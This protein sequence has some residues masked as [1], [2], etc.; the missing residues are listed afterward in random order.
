M[1]KAKNNSWFC[2][3]CGEESFTYLGRCA[4]CGAWGSLKESPKAEKVS[5]RSTF[6]TRA[7]VAAQKLSQIK[8]NKNQNRLSTGSEEFD[9]VLGGG[10]L[11]DSLI[12]LGGEPG[13]GK[14]TLLLQTA[15]A[16]AEQG[17]VLY[18]SAE[19]SSWQIKGRAERL[20]CSTEVNV[21]TETNLAAIILEV[22][23]L[24]PIITI[25]DS[26]QAVFSPEADGLPGSISQ[27][28]QCANQLFELAKRGGAPVILVGHV[29]KEGS[30]AG[31]KMLEHLVDAVVYFEGSKQGDSR[32]LRCIKNRFGSTDELG[33]FEM[34]EAGLREVADPSAH[35]L[36]RGAL[37]EPGSVVLPA[38]Q[39]SR[40]ILAEVQALVCSSTY[41]QP[42]RQV[43]GLDFNRVNQIIAVLDKRLGLAL[44]KYDVYVN[45]TGGLQI[46][47]PAA[48]LAIAVAIVGSLR[49]LP[50]RPKCVFFGEIGLAGE[51]R[52]VSKGE[53][54]QK[55]AFRQG[56]T[57]AVLPHSKEMKK[58]LGGDLVFADNL[59]DALAG[60][61]KAVAKS[62]RA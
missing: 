45:A 56:F 25:I 49:N 61:F 13:I 44:S 47:E 21:L 57:T 10:V 30:I 12:L 51:L 7:P 2:T 33:V 55:E 43:N 28:R 26:I 48:D 37:D 53:L 27:V 58:D 1:R 23:R 17:E 9:R 59:I 5:A 54:R 41:P 42:K 36:N 32:I 4:S 46:D 50:T 6:R 40:A 38:L 15:S 35:F 20:E 3:E 52:K 34:S 62:V 24:E 8:P 16:F 22:E 14:S 60:A 39:G 11:G 19:E 31:P 29:T 18:V